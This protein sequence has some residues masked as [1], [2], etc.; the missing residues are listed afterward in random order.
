MGIDELTITMGKQGAGE[1][2]LTLDSGETL[3]VVLDDVE[4]GEQRGFHA[5]GRNEEREMLYE[6]TTGPQ[7]GGSIQLRGRPLYEEEWE[8]IGV[9]TDARK[10][11]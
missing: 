11:G 6:L 9:V 7:P 10:L 1:W 4:V 8:D 3:D 5:E 2:R